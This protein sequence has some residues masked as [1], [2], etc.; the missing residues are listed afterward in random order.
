MV[1][2]HYDV[3]VAG[4]G[5]AGVV[6][7]IASAR[8]GARTLLT[9]RFPFLGGNATAG[10]LGNFLTFHNMK[11]EQICNGIPQEIVDACIKLGGCFPDN[12][13]HLLNPYGNAYTVTPVDGEVLKLVT[14]KL[15]V[16]AGVTLMLN[17]YT[18]APLVEETRV[19]GIRVVNKSGEQTLRA[20]VVIDATGDADLVAQAGGPFLLGD[21]TGRTMSISLFFRLGGVDLAEHLAYV[22]QRP[23][24][25]MLG[26]DPFIGKTREEIAAG[27]RHW[28][29]YPLVTGYYDA[30]REAK[31][32]EEFHKNRER[33]VFSITTIPGVV[34]VN[35][36][37]MLGLNP[38]DGE[39]LTQAAL[40]GREQ[41]FVVAN[42][43]RKYVP[44]FAA[45]FVLDSAAALGVRESR[46]IVGEQVLTTE[47]CLD[48]RT[49]D[50]D[51]A[52]G[53]YCLDVHEAS[54]RI[55]HKHVK[56]GEAYGV[57]YGCLVPKQIDGI[58][59]A[60]RALSSERYANGSVRVQ[61]HIMAIGQAAGTA[62]ALCAA[63]G[64]LPREVAVSELRSH[65][66]RDGAVV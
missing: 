8:Q 4:G 32:R 53:A 40:E 45:A 17:T 52:R 37:S 6:A 51:I 49:S 7:A 62:G 26:E 38:T 1:D 54:G 57:P 36:T 24:Q 41:I 18:I 16:A 21:D 2:T 13:G 39:G 60:G 56:D 5:M 19:V 9:D 44:G 10:L 12:R 48:G 42:F 27:L 11:G 64:W 47:A 50:A 31:A 20:R 28:K 22:K 23:D 58:L 55:V 46:R 34:T 65:L 14:Q 61:A 43:F 15:C 25:F 30:V 66:V 63:K 59:V 3:V 35:S 33:V 29:D